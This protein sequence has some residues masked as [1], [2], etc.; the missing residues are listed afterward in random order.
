MTPAAVLAWARRWHGLK[1][2]PATRAL[3]AGVAALAASA[4]RRPLVT[5]HFQACLNSRDLFRVV[6]LVHVAECAEPGDEL[7]GWARVSARR[8]AVAAFLKGL[9]S[10]AKTRFD[11]GL[12]SRVWDA[13]LAAG[14]GGWYPIV[15][16]EHHVADGAFPEVSL[17][18]EHR[19]PRA[20]A[21]AARLMAPE[22]LA[23]LGDAPLFA[24]GLDLLADGRSRLKLYFSAPPGAAG[25]LLKDLDGRLCP[26][27]SLSLLRTK[28]E[29]GFETSSKAYLPLPAVTSG[30]VTALSGDEFP[31]AARGSLGTFARTVARAVAGQHLFYIGASSEKTEV[32]F[33]AGEPE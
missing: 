22:A 1:A 32:Y 11:A 12:V 27:R 20:A 30:R 10:S 3:S 18:A 23:R 31:G 15:G 19:A 9:N 28:P 26:P 33:G 13:V 25:G 2:G 24:L 14:A 6:K 17:Y 8:R 5:D 7:G 29:G 4:G 16:F 21:A